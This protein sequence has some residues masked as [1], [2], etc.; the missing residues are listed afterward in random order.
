MTPSRR[1]FLTLPGATAITCNPPWQP[2][3]VEAKARPLEDFTRNIPSGCQRKDGTYLRIGP[4]TSQWKS[5][6][7]F[8]I[9]TRS[10]SD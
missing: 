5:P 3:S 9:R 1:E 7:S 4:N 2:R 8:Y 6:K 10:C